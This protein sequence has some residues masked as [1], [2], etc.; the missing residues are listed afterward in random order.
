MK[1]AQRFFIRYEFLL[2]FITRRDTTII[3]AQKSNAISVSLASIRG[4]KFA[5][6]ALE[7]PSY[8]PGQCASRG[9]RKPGGDYARRGESCH[10]KTNSVLSATS[11]YHLSFSHSLFLATYNRDERRERKRRRSRRRGEE[12]EGNGNRFSVR[13]VSNRGATP[14][15]SPSH[16]NPRV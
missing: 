6:S 14:A 9:R 4:I 3:K 11:S 12:S 15:S 16:T 1:L 2:V 13:S 7:F 5:K 8:F 10:G